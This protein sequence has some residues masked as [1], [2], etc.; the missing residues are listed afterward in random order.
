VTE[1]FLIKILVGLVDYCQSHARAVLL[2]ALILTVGSIYYASGHLGLVADTNQL[3][4]PDLPWQKI[5]SDFD[6]AFPSTTMQ[7]A[8]LIEGKSANAVDNGTAEL[9]D[10]LSKRPDLFKT[11]QRPDSGPFFDTNGILFLSLDELAFFSDEIAQ[12][13]PLLAPVNADPSLRGLFGILDMATQDLVQ[14]GET[15]ANLAEPLN[16]FADTIRSVA[17]GKP[18]RLDWGALITAGPAQPEELRHFILVQPALD[19]GALQPGARA[20]AA[21]REMAANLHFPDRFLT[22]RL[23][24]EVP[25]ADEEFDSAT[26][27][28]GLETALSMFSVV[29]ILLFGL[30]A[31]RLIFAIMVTLMA[32]LAI[33]AAFAATAVGSLNVISVAFA[34]LF[35][36]IG[37]DFGIQFT[38]RFR[39]EL[40]DLTGGE[41]PADKAAINRQALS[42]TARSIAAPLSVAGLAISLGFFAF[43]PTDY[44]GVSELGLIAGAS[45]LVALL[46]NLTV[47]PALLSLLP[48][49]GKAEA[50]GFA[51]AAP[52]DR[53]LARRA[54][55][56]LLLSIAAAI[57]AGFTIVHVRFDG[58][59]LNLKDPARESVIVT[60]E[61]ASDPSATPY[62]IEILT[63]GPAEAAAL[64]ARLE[65]LPQVRDVISL[66]S[67]IPGDQA[68]K[69]DTIEQTKFLL[70]PLLDGKPPL[71]APHDDEEREAARTFLLHLNAALAARDESPDQTGQTLADAV[72]AFLAMPGGGNIAVL[73]QA[74]LGGFPGRIESLRHAM[75]AAPVSVETL[76]PEIRNDWIAADG[77]ARISVFPKGDMRDRA[78][79]KAFV[80]A[81]LGVAPDATGMPVDI[82]E[83][84]GTVAAAFV[85]AS[86]FALIAIT[87]FLGA[88]LRSFRDV[89]L[90]LIPLLLAG[91]LTL[92]T[93]VSIGL[94]FNFLNIIALPLL[95]G[96]GVAFD[97]YFV[98]AWRSMRAQAGKVALLQTATARAVVFSAFTTMT[99]F[100]SLALSPH[101]GTASLGRFL[102]IALFYVLFCTL[103]VQPALMNVWGRDKKATITKI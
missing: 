30:R 100:G 69:L 84:G 65:T 59:P 48:A 89:L 98:M 31:P 23:T 19:F 66:A 11:V 39:A 47:L 58:D 74:L 45:M 43:L 22:V 97:I 27:G 33:T 28:A 8:I 60:R 42:R 79:L 51:W 71:P 52:I 73:R 25:L 15:R 77:R 80:D 67:Y 10:A 88:V 34:V 86:L 90:V 21:I 76:P 2:T 81:V 95:M 64:R 26:A 75:A 101:A 37:V 96:I 3:F 16:A 13:Q 1:S 38:M 63:R 102:I 9:A 14:R 17:A 61:M 53:F 83:A 82:F 7:T 41:S 85:S 93:T 94:D 54:K 4:S 70:G 56:V 29:V 78:Q 50:A 87:L 49:R 46:A 91:L 103:F 36:G 35:I 68:A 12:A 40:F 99:A 5:Q 6:R 92:A 24:G 32:G 44:K 72:T 20:S 55:A 18:R 57:A 62:R